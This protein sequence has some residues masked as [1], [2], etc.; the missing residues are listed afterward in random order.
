MKRE[1]G[2]TFVYDF[3]TH[4]CRYPHAEL[5]YGEG[6]DHRNQWGQGIYETNIWDKCFREEMGLGSEWPG[7]NI[8]RWTAFVLGAGG[9]AGGRN[10]AHNCNHPDDNTGT[11]LIGD[12]QLSANVTKKLDPACVIEYG[13][14]V[15]GQNG[16]CTADGVAW[17]HEMLHMFGVPCHGGSITPDWFVLPYTSWPM[18]SDVQHEPM[19]NHLWPGQKMSLFANSPLFLG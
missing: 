13:G 11:A 17:A 1:T 9:W 16:P 15:I 7:K 2:V 18:Q 12:Y 4:V 19:A 8:L 3:E 10:T 14:G 6:R 5:A